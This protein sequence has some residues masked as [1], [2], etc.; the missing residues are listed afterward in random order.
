VGR[1]TET[2]AAKATTIAGAAA[3][4]GD[5]AAPRAVARA[6]DACGEP[7][8]LVLAFPSGLE[9]V[10]V[11]REIAV[12]G[13]G[14][15]CVGLTGKGALGPD[16]IVEEGCS[17][18]AFDSSVAT[19]VASRPAQPGELRA[20][21]TAA[22]D[23][24]LRALAGRPHVLLL[25]LLDT[26]HSDHAD[27]VAGAYEVAGTEVPIAGGGAGGPETALLDGDALGDS[28]LAVAIAPPHG[29]GLGTADGCVTVAAPATV[30]ASDGL[31]VTE[32]DHRPAE[33]LY[34]ERHEQDGRLDDE[35][36]EA[37]AVTHPLA[38]TGPDGER[39]MRHIRWREGNGLACATHLPVGAEVAFSHQAPADIIAASS[40][41]VEDSL[42]ALGRRPGAALV[43][44]CAGRKRAI[45]GSLGL[46]SSALYAAFDAVPPIAGAFTYGEVGRSSRPEGDLN[47]A[48]VVATLA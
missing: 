39:R 6:I 16:G 46:E 35:D 43:F 1:G 11:A 38:Q 28:V 41:A 17:A 10:R 14:A 2:E 21:A 22:S 15:R 4:R 20:A 29:V 8:G 3:A 34:L 45:G 19:A 9:P 7:P 44:D 36:F 37:F 31:V 13:D 24:V 25:L 42:S 30:T 32:L 12:A 48:I 18:I 27:A 23:E 33:E 40:R 5:D 26:P 47:H